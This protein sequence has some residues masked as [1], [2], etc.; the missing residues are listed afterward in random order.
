MTT[1]LVI[2]GETCTWNAKTEFPAKYWPNSD[3]L[4]IGAR[5]H[6]LG[7]LW[8]LVRKLV[9]FAENYPKLWIIYGKQY[10]DVWL[11]THWEVKNRCSMSRV[12]GMS[13]QD[14]EGAIDLFGQHDPG[15]FVGKGHCAE[16]EQ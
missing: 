14:G 4:S 1:F 6:E 7:R 13:S 11:V 15:E 9:E 12:V 3:Y 5:L 8:I 16:R 2:A 10:G